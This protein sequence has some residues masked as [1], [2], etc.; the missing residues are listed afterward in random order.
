[1]KRAF[2]SMVCSLLAVSL[3]ASGTFAKGMRG[4]YS[5]YGFA[6]MRETPRS[7]AAKS[8]SM[9]QAAALDTV[10]LGWWQFDNASGTPNEQGW[11]EHDMTVQLKKYWH[12]A[13]TPCSDAIT[14]ISGSKSMWCGQWTSTSAPWCGWSGLPG[15]GNGWNQSFESIVNVTTIS[16]AITWDTEPG[17]D[18]ACLEWWDPVTLVWTADPTANG[19]AGG[20]TG[21]GSLVESLTTPYGATKVRFHYLS[22]WAGSDED[23][24]FFSAE[25]AVMIDDVAIDGGFPETYESAACNATA[26]GSFQATIPSGFGEFGALHLGTGVVQED[27]YERVRSNLW[28][29][30]DNP[31]VTNYS[32]GGWPLQGAVPYGPDADGLY[33]DNEIWSP[34]VPITGSG[35][36]F[37]L[38]FL[39]YRDLPLDNLIFYAWHVRTQA[40]VDGCPSAWRD[41]GLIYH[42]D[43]K[44]WIRQDFQLGTLVDAAATHIQVALGVVDMFGWWGGMYGSG[45][46]H[47]HAPLIDEVRIVRI[48]VTGTRWSRQTNLMW[49]DNFPELGGIGP[50]PENPEAEP[51]YARCDMAF[52]TCRPMASKGGTGGGGII[53]GDSL[54]AWV[55]DPAGLATDNTGGR[56]GKAVYVFVSAQDRYGNIRPYLAAQM[57]SPDWEAWEDDPYEG[58][59]RWPLVEDPTGELPGGWYCYRMD[60]VYLP[61]GDPVEDEYCADLMDLAAGPDGPPYHRFELWPANTGRFQPGDVICYFLGAKNTD[62][63]WS[64]LTRNHSGQGDWFYPADVMAAVNSAMEWSVLPDAG[65]LAGDAGDILFVD[66][67]DDCLIMGGAGLPQDYFDQTWRIYGLTDRVDRF[68]VLDSHLASTNNSLAS[69]VKSIQN[70]IIGT[71]PWPE[72]YQKILWNCSG[73]EYALMGDG[74]R[75][76]GGSSLEESDDFGLAWTFLNTHPDNPGW[77]YFGADVIKDW[78]SLCGARA[79][80]VKTSF[81][82]YTFI[83]DDQSAITGEVWPRVFQVTSSPF[84]DSFQ[85]GMGGSEWIPKYDLAFEEGTSQSAHRYVHQAGGPVASLIQETPNAEGSTARFFLAGYGLDQVLDDGTR[86]PDGAGVPDYALLLKEL[87]EWFQN[88]VG[89]PVGI[90]PV[91]SFENRLENNYPNPFN[92]TT[93]IEYG[94]RERGHVTLKIYNAAGQL[95]TTLVDEEQSP[96]AE[97]FSVNW[98]GTSNTGGNAASGVYFYRLTAK[99]FSQTKKLVL[100]K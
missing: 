5:G 23:G 34:V 31:A 32:C 82:N 38:E 93:T 84:T 50:T 61:S 99:D 64:F 47:S 69:R 19:S 36:E 9:F 53:P 30:F 54:V 29:W 17:R 39:A 94:I 60:Y 98:D 63:E 52:D 66:D 80:D 45:A 28:G 86:Y 48:P 42:G 40:A 81:M 58:Y 35:N 89:D 20:Y 88:L 43:G 8:G 13:G 85:T 83:A 49:Q 97:G 51:A 79:V 70:Q 100:L 78:N 71:E 73:L 11:T 22:D 26:A 10:V 4:R 46:C 90:D 91:A 68:D 27:P 21:N 41:C 62:D 12:V 77:A 1:M 76:N 87:I 96:R 3:G 16:Y 24:L 18:Y 37:V 72:V 65:R 57:Q 55:F 74:G 25:G 75:E 44:Y 59:L 92:P 14:P 56:P 15:Y 67:A 33:M 6:E 2:V 7:R 95:V